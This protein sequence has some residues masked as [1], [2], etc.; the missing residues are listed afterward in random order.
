MRRGSRKPGE[1]AT[2]AQLGDAQLDGVSAGFP[3][4]IAIAVALRKPL[5]AL[6]AVGGAGLVLDLE[7][8]QPLGG[9]TDHVA[10]DVG[11]LGIF[12]N[13]VKRHHLVGHRWLLEPG[14]GFAT[15]PRANR[16]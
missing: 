13:R 1:I 15:R 7:L 3:A 9:K 2:L 6:L 10:Q 4:A 8:H 16:R 14:W 11:V 5:A 12:N